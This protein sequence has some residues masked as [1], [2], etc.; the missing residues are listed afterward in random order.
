M[1]TR[2]PFRNQLL[3]ASAA[4]LVFSISLH[5]QNP[6]RNP[7]KDTNV[8]QTSL[9]LC[10]G[11][12]VV[13]RESVPPGTAIAASPD[14]SFLATWVHTT[15]GAALDLHDRDSGTTQRVE[16]VPPALPPGITWRVQE[17]A[18]SRDGN[19]LAVRT[20][21]AVWVIDRAT[22]NVQFLIGQDSATQAYP[23][24]ISW[25]NNELAV[26]FW[27]AESYLADAINTGPVQVRIYY[28]ATGDVGR[29]I[30]LT[31]PSS[32]N[33]T[34]PRLSPDGN[35]LAV[36]LRARQWPGKADLF[37]FA[38]DTGKLLWQ[39]KIGAEDLLWT[40]D[41][42]QIVA[43]GSDL[44]W[45]DAKKGKQ[46]RKANPSVPHSEFQ[47][48]RVNESSQVAVGSFSVYSAMERLFKSNQQHS[49][50][51][52]LWH[53]D[54]ASGICEI[55][56]AAVNT[57]DAWPTARSEIISLEETYEIKPPLRLLKSAQIVTY[58]LA[59]P[60]EP[61]NPPKP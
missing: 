18:F 43:L 10:A 26:S 33:W 7:K 9:S 36:L 4:L 3:A 39:K 54:T 12:E 50:K 34:E 2:L 58:R 41:G 60:T 14:G 28:A 49:E 32:N 47:K 22:A 24:K 29:D 46:V 38:S 37:L 57:I 27:P 35:Q 5:S 55:P 59:Q 44:I 17:V 51:I 19:K 42:K 21:G 25:G 6:T 20:T 1:A 53:F 56:I 30:S 16:L 31:L 23:G 13:S 61:A 52:V 11:L 48:L 40:A 45:L 15:T 8:P